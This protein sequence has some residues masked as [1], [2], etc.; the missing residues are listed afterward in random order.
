MAEIEMAAPPREERS[1]KYWEGRVYSLEERV[2]VLERRNGKE[3]DN[4]RELIG[5]IAKLRD[6]V[7]VVD[8]RQDQ[9]AGNLIEVR[10]Q[11]K[12]IHQRLDGHD[13]RFEQIDKRFEGIEKTQAEHGEMLQQILERLPS[14]N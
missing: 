7:G 12:M 2:Y 3:D 11:V 5:E 14:L 13:K 4:H 6:K 8:L 9:L 10:E 1:F